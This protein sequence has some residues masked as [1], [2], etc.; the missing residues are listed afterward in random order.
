MTAL[1]PPSEIEQIVG[2]TRHPTHHYGRAVSA[3]RTVYILHSQECR[4]T[5]DDLR[6]CPFSLALDLGIDPERGP[7][8]GMEDRPVRLGRASGHI[9]PVEELAARSTPPEDQ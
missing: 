9:V 1:V 5:H 8:A 6:N 4:D 7:W 2:A 3:E